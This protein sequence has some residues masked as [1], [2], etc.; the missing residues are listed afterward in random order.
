LSDKLPQDWR[1]RSASFRA[2][3]KLLI[4][5]SDRVT[6]A[7]I[8]DLGAGNGWLSKRLAG[9]GHQMTAVDLLDNDWD[10][11]G[12]HKHFKNAF[13]PVQAEFGKLPFVVAQFDAIIFNASIH[14]SE[15]YIG[16]ISGLLPLLSPGGNIFIIDTPV[17]ESRG[18]G[19]KMVQE[20]E[21]FFE[22]KYGFASA[23]LESKN[24]L[25][26]GEINDIVRELGLDLY[27]TFPSFPPLWSFTRWLGP[28]TGRREAA[29]FPV[30][31]LKKLDEKIV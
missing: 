2:L 6:Q 19:E 25:T 30:I 23:S 26:Y 12:A 9:A 7:K 24:F 8:L 21:A 4:F 27:L 1:V 5:Q 15:D 10:G 18:S 28:F 29:V 17:Y 31:S 13:V 20:R 3:Q 16:L 14:Y 22:Q 11:L